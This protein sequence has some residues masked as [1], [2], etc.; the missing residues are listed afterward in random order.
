ME[1]N[2]VAIKMSI[3]TGDFDNDGFLDIYVANT[4]LGNKFIK[5]SV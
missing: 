4:S 3:A 1:T 2:N 5:N